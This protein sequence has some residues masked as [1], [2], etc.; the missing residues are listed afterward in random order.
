MEP[1]HF[2]ALLPPNLQFNWTLVTRLGDMLTRAEQLYGARDHSWT[3]L[4][5]EFGG[6]IPQI[7]YPGDTNHIAI[8]LSSHVLDSTALAYYQL[9]H[10]CIHLLSPTKSAP[11]LEEG[12]ATI[13]A[14]DYVSDLFGFTPDSG[15]DCY[16]QA[17]AL[18]RELLVI[19]P[20]AIK[21]LRAVE[22]SF[23]KMSSA[24]FAMAQ[25]HV[26][27]PLMQALTQPFVRD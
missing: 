1:T 7:W 27:E 24:T 2:Q 16:R 26:P 17:V 4:G 9:A 13:F 6:D 23:T 10:E 12:L 19:E 20:D 22:P 15:M 18:V 21:R 11:L 25:L 5:I 14:E 3:I 8:Q